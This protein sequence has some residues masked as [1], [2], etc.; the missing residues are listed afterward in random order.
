MYISGRA[1]TLQTKKIRKNACSPRQMF[2][3]LGSTFATEFLDSNFCN[4]NN[5]EMSVFGSL[6]T[7]DTFAMWHRPSVCL[8]KKQKKQQASKRTNELGE[9][10]SHCALL[11]KKKKDVEKNNKIARHSLLGG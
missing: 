3:C 10:M 9:S 8:K 6:A 1:V 11:G 7:V 5:G 2:Q 4:R